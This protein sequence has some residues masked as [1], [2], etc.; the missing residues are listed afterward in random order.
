MLDH[1]EVLLNQIDGV[2]FDLD[3]VIVDSEALHNESI[4]AAAL[5]HGLALTDDFFATFMGQPDETILAHLSS[6]YLR[7]AVSPEQLMDEKQV[8]YRDLAG[9]LAAIPGAVEFIHLVRAAGMPIGLA[10]SSTLENQ[11]LAFDR[12][13]LH[14]YFDVVVTVEDVALPK[15]APEPYALAAARL[16]IAPAACLVI[17]DSL[18]GVRAGKGAGCYVVGLT[19]SY[20]ASALQSA[21]ADRVYGSYA[22]IAHALGLQRLQALNPAASAAAGLGK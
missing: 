13:H 22:E 11:R 8:I 9:Q 21:G 3:G 16:Q 19:T 4:K 10:T 1:N 18:N 12:F 20:P 6:R 7:G 2:I 15:P 5:Q 17:E 14:G